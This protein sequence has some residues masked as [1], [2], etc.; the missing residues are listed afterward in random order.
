MVSCSPGQLVYRQINIALDN[1]ALAYLNTFT[2]IPLLQSRLVHYKSSKRVLSFK[3]LLIS[4]ERDPREKDG[5]YVKNIVLFLFLIID[6]SM[7][8]FH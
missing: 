2:I 1:R 6:K 5:I 7:Q 3:F 4:F 8:L